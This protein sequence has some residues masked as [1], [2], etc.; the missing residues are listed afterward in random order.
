MNG[1]THTA[2]GIATGLALVSVLPTVTGAN[3]TDLTFSLGA[4]VIGA[5]FP[6]LDLNQSK[7]NQ[8]LNKV[9]ACGI[10]ALN[11]K[12]ESLLWPSP[13]KYCFSLCK[14]GG[15]GDKAIG[16]AAGVLSVLLLLGGAT[17]WF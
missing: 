14:A 6:D 13:G 2:V 1:K 10:P 5:L 16:Y 17:A 12:G 15:V 11:T 4:S 7:G 9:L 3:Y 8:V